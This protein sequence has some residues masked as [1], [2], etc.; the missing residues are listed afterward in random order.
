M[1]NSDSFIGEVSEEVRR[2]RL[3]HLLRRYGWIGLAI[4]VLIVGG[5]AVYEWRQSQIAAEAQ[6]RGDALL[7]ALAEPEAAA[8]AEALAPI[9]AQSEDAVVLQLALAA[10]QQ[11]AGDAE[12][13]VATLDALAGNGEVAEIYRDLAALKSVLIDAGRSP[14][15]KLLALEALS[16]PGAPFRMLAL[17]QIALIRLAQGEQDAAVDQLRA[18]M[19]DAETTPDLR[20]RA[21]SLMVALGVPPEDAAAAATPTE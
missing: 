13:A 10:E 17:E 21:A 2:D 19:E 5:A 20:D 18:I 6:A 8:R 16:A 11:A 14:E 7:A 4:V 9:A 1:S 3:F 15:D 12:A